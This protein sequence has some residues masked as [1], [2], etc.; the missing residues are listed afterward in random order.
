MKE[1]RYSQLATKAS[2]F[3][4]SSRFFFVF[5]TLFLF[6]FFFFKKKKNSHFNSHREMFAPNTHSFVQPTAQNGINP[7]SGDAMSVAHRLLF[8]N[9]EN[10]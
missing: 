10:A 6:S 7:D 5:P 3:S 1:I 9:D 4:F 8:I 2:S